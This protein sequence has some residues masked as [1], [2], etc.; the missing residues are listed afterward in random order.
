MG[1][2]VLDIRALDNGGYDIKTNKGDVRARFVV[3]SA[4]GYSLLMA[5]KLNYGLKYSCLPMAGSFYFS[6]TPV[7]TLNF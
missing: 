3:A 1:T 6:K 7:N 5:H 2:E 4:C